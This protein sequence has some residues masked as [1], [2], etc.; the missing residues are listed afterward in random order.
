MLAVAL[1][2]V[3]VAF[4]KFLVDFVNASLVSGDPSGEAPRAWII[5]ASHAL[6]CA[7]VL[8][9]L[10]S[11]RRR[12]R[13][14]ESDFEGEPT[15]N[16]WKNITPLDAG[17][18]LAGYAL[19]IGFVFLTAN[20]RQPDPHEDWFLDR[21]GGAVVWGTAIGFLGILASQY[22]F[23]RRRE[24]FW[25]GERLGIITA[26]LLLSTVLLETLMA[27]GLGQRVIVLLFASCLIQ[28]DLSIMSAGFLFAK[29]FTRHRPRPRVEPP[30]TDILGYLACAMTGPF[31]CWQFFDGL[32][33]L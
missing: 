6:V 30:R 25:T 8:C 7:V 3:A 5:F 31:I 20:T 2:G 4:S 23:R 15:V 12:L 29:L 26:T 18:L 27:S 22:V 19:G 9:G 28:C 16:A 11:L 33:G 17:I 13:G 21:I 32:A 14:R 1:V 24:P 10:L